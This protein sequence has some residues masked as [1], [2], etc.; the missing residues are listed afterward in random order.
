MRRTLGLDVLECPRYGG[1]LRLLAYIEPA[2]AVECILRH[3]GLA[4]DRPE[5]RPARHFAG[6]F[7]WGQ[8]IQRAGRRNVLIGAA[9]V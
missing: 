1:W 7:D 5:P 2:P 3:V 4:T 6:G 9:V 8:P